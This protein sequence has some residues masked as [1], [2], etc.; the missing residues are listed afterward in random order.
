LFFPQ[1]LLLLYGKGRKERDV[2]LWKNT[3]AFLR[4]YMAADME[5]KCRTLEKIQEP[6]GNLFQFQPDN[7]VT[8]FL[9]SL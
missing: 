2:P 5:M 8:A 6:E 1:T 4:K 7:T 9:D 3:S